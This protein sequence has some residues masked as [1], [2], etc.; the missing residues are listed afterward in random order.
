MINQLTIKCSS[1]KLRS[2]HS[3]LKILILT[4]FSR[5]TW[6]SW[7]QNVFFLD[8]IGAKDD[9]ELVK[10]SPS[11]NQKYSFLFFL[12]LNWHCQSTDGI[13]LKIDV[14]FSHKDACC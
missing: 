9:P 1:C 13:E 3:V 7:Y 6:V 11:T 10:L 4:Y 12:S 2:C 8:F 5:R 14:D